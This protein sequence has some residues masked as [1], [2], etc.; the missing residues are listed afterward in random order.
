[1]ATWLPTTLIAIVLVVAALLVFLRVGFQVQCCFTP[2][3]TIRLI[4]DGEPRTAAST[5]T[6]LLNYAVGVSK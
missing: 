3:E 2:T 4:R 1:M 6:H 5:F